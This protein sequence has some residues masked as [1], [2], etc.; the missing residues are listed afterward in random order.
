MSDVMVYTTPT[1]P[2]CSKVKDYLTEKG[3]SYE[4]L[5]VATD[6][7]AADKMIDLTGQRSV[8]VIAKAGLFVV[9][10]SP[11]QIDKLLI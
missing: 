6:S 1:C 3:I 4:E 5:N 7:E 8:P 2:W 11:E 9:G 10:Y